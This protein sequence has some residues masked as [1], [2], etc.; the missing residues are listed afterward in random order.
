MGITIV[1]RPFIKRNSFEYYAHGQLTFIR[2]GVSR[3]VEG[4]RGIN[5]NEEENEESW[6]L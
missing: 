4:M 1:L 2:H 5:V 6:K 3:R